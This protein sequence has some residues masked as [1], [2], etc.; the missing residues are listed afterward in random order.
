MRSMSSGGLAEGTAI[1][2]GSGLGLGSGDA[3]NVRSNRTA[4][5]AGKAAAATT[6]HLVMIPYLFRVSEEP[7]V[8]SK[9]VSA[10]VQVRRWI[11]RRRVAVFGHRDFEGVEQCADCVVPPEQIRQI[12]QPLATERLLGHAIQR[13][14]YAMLDSQ[15]PRVA[16]GSLFLVGE[17]LGARHR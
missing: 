5:T 6:G 9:S 11:G 8:A 12:H 1:S 16:M 15:L 7:T 13:V 10:G 2:V 17:L 4:G 14:I 3:T